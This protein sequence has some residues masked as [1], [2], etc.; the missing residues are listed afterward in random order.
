MLSDDSEVG[1]E[2]PFLRPTILFDDAPSVLVQG[3]YIDLLLLGI[4]QFSVILDVCLKVGDKFSDKAQREDSRIFVILEPEQHSLLKQRTLA[5]SRPSNDQ[6]LFCRMLRDRFCI[7]I[8]EVF[9]LFGVKRIKFTS[10]R[11]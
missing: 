9:A 7:F 11:S 4:S 8:A 10:E 6:N 1:C 2:P 5:S 3:E